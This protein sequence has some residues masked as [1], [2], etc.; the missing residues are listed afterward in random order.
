MSYLKLSL[1]TRQPGLY[2]FLPI[3]YPVASTGLACNMP[4]LNISL[5]KDCQYLVVVTLR[6]L[7]VQTYNFFS[8]PLGA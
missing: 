3:E 6:F 4:T 2:I 1:L 7:V 8:E 5:I